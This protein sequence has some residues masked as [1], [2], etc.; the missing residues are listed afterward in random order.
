MC[1]ASVDAVGYRLAM[2]RLALAGSAASSGKF[3]PRV[4]ELLYAGQAGLMKV[5]EAADAPVKAKTPAI[6]SR[7]AS[8]P[9]HAV[10][11]RLAASRAGSAWLSGER[12]MG[13]L[14]DAA[15]AGFWLG[16]ARSA[17]AR[18]SRR[19]SRRSWMPSSSST[20]SSTG[21]APTRSATRP[22]PLRTLNFGD[23]SEGVVTFL[24]YPPGDLVLVATE[25]GEDGRHLA[26]DLRFSL[27]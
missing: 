21:A 22:A 8:D 11:L 13:D 25:P 14:R 1:A 17:Q 10:T 16:E 3:G 9:R 19:H 2:H 20:R 4:S 7:T 24:I 23:N 5:T 27:Q 26:P 15:D 6:P 12:V 18:L